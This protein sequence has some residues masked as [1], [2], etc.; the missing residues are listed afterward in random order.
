MSEMQLLT[1]NIVNERQK[2]EKGY[3]NNN[4]NK[5]KMKKK[6]TIQ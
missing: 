4:N 6:F 2:S 1:E 3:N 5:N